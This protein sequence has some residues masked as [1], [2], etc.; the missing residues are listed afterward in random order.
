MTSFLKYFV[1]KN[2]IQNNYL[3]HKFAR[4]EY[5][6]FHVKNQTGSHVVV[7]SPND[8]N[9]STI[10][11]AANLAVIHSKSKDSSSVP[12]DYT[13]IKY[14]K[15]IPGMLGSFVS[16]TNQKTIYIDPDHSIIKDLLKKARQ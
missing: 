6:W 12:V 10:R 11:L 2:N 9:E 5:W 15:K 8:L 14:I 4:K 7:G 3:T 13:K 1:G 16:Y